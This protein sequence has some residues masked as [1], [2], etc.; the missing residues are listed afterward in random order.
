MHVMARDECDSVVHECNKVGAPSACR[1]QLAPCFRAIAASE[2][3]RKKLAAPRSRGAQAKAAVGQTREAVR[4][5]R[6]APAAARRVPIERRSTAAPNAPSSLQR[7]VHSGSRGMACKE[8]PLGA[9]QG[10]AQRFA[11][12]CCL[13]GTPLRPPGPGQCAGQTGGAARGARARRARGT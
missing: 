12:G 9:Q 1:A 7:R 8:A 5:R 2:A 10:G 4:A 6:A 13:R 3:R 11:S